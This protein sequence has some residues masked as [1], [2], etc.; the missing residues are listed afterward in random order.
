MQRPQSQKND[1]EDGIFTSDIGIRENSAFDGLMTRVKDN[2]S[3]TAGSKK[4]KAAAGGTRRAKKGDV[5]VNGTITGRA[6]K[7][8]VTKSLK[9]TSK[10]SAEQS[11]RRSEE[12][13]LSFKEPRSI[14]AEWEIDMLH[15]EAATKRRN[16][17]TPVKDTVISTLD[18]TAD[19]DTSPASTMGTGGQ[20]FTSLLSDY[21][22]TKGQ[23]SITD[24]EYRGQA[25]T[26][27]RRLE[28]RRMLG[29]S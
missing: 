3:T 29:F 15:L 27:K 8:S 21:A 25:P 5:L 17:W 4:S 7:A 1:K 24:T 2:P 12:I 22:F 20:R 11:L 10:A 19:S 16:D 9:S 23:T 18:L 14:G 6:T 28:V 13:P 26:K